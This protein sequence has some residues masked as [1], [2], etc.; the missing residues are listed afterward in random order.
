M[1]DADTA[2]VGG[3]DGLNSTGGAYLTAA[4][5]VGGAEALVK[6][7]LGLEEGFQV[8]RGT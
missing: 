6:R 7:H 2:L 3:I 4:G 1:S 5:A 8:F